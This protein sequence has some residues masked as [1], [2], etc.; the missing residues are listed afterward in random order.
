MVFCMCGSVDSSL[1]GKMGYKTTIKLF[2]FIFSL[3]VKLPNYF[4]WKVYIDKEK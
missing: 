1:L 3:I 4:L 2:L